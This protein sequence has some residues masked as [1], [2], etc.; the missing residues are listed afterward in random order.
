MLNLISKWGPMPSSVRLSAA[1]FLNQTFC[2]FREQA[3]L[4]I[5][6]LFF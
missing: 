3:L 4:I 6:I 5:H 1:Q 2:L